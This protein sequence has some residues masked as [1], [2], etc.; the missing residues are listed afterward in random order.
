MFG[1]DVSGRRN[2][3]DRKIGPDSHS[4]SHKDQCQFVAGTE[5]PE[6]SGP[7]DGPAVAKAA[8]RVKKYGS[9]MSE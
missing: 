8:H 1:E 4:I 5:K 2:I 3:R 9:F 7:R 6:I